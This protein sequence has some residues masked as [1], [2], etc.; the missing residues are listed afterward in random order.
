MRCFPRRLP[1]KY[2]R[3]VLCCGVLCCGVLR[4]AVLWYVVLC[5]VVLC[6]QKQPKNDT[7]RHN[8]AQATQQRCVTKAFER[9]KTTQEAARR[10]KNDMEQHQATQQSH[11]ECLKTTQHPQKRHL[12][13][14]TQPKQP[15]KVALRRLLNAAR[16][17]KKPQEAIV[18]AARRAK[19][20]MLRLKT[21]K[22]AKQ[23]CLSK[24]FEF[25]KHLIGNCLKARNFSHLFL[26]GSRFWIENAFRKEIL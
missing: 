12:D 21:A 19:I 6:V 1:V 26:H 20:A 18:N 17:P 2:K 4:Y 24:A 22:T 7:E 23:R 25:I 15:H 16:R 8:T 11:L 10:P 14:I 13:N 3:V 5:C 9:R